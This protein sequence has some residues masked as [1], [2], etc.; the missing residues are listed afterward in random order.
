MLDV[1]AD[2][3][4]RLDGVHGRLLAD[5]QRL[6]LEVDQSSSLIGLVERQ[7]LST[8]A[9]YLAQAGCT[10]HVRSGERLLLVAG[11]EAKAGL[12]GRLL[13]LPRVQISRRFALRATLSRVRLRQ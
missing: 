1:R 3:K 5:G 7:S 11:H 8:L 13:R 9:G 4:V 6:V 2:V 10:L 12:L